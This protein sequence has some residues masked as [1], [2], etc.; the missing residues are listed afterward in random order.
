MKPFCRGLLPLF[1]DPLSHAKH[2]SAI[3]AHIFSLKFIQYIMEIFAGRLKSPAI[4][5]NRENPSIGGD[6]NRPAKN[7]INVQMSSLSISDILNIHK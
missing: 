6:L 5:F 4:D 2:D 3:R 7:K 1:D